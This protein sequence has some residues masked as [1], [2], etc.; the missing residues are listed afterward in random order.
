MR[1]RGTKK[2][3]GTGNKADTLAGCVFLS[4]IGALHTSTMYGNRSGIS[5]ID[6]RRYARHILSFRRCHL[7]CSRLRCHPRTKYWL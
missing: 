3:K 4:R 6:Q 7:S 1:P 5:R 2:S